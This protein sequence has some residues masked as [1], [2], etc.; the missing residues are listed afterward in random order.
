[1]F[2]SSKWEVYHIHQARMNAVL[3]CLVCFY[4]N[5]KGENPFMRMRNRCII[6]AAFRYVAFSIFTALNVAV[7]WRKQVNLII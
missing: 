2:T 3:C 4:G 6:Y 1:M 7:H 5:T